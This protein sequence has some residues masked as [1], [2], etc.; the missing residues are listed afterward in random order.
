MF[1]AVHPVR[2]LKPWDA[3][4]TITTGNAELGRLKILKKHHHPDSHWGQ[5]IDVK[6]L[7]HPN[8][9]LDENDYLLC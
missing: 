5:K 1:V 3:T 4:R 6:N 2:P 9:H 8:N 7:N